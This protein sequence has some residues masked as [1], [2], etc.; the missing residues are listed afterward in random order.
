MA[1]RNLFIDYRLRVI[2]LGLVM[3]WLATGAFAVAGARDPGIT[4]PLVIYPLGAM[5]AGLALLTITPW[6][7]VLNRPYG[8]AVIAIWCAM[9]VGGVLV[10]DGLGDGAGD[11]VIA[12]FIA[13][14]VFAAAALVAP[15][16]L[17]VVSFLALGGYVVTLVGGDANFSDL[18]VRFAAFGLTAVLLLVAAGGI[19]NQVQTAAKRLDELGERDAE[20]TKRESELEKLYDISRTIGAGVNLAEVLPELVG[21]LAHAVEARTGLVLLYRPESE[22]LEV[23]SPIWVAGHTVRVDGYTLPLQDAGIAQRVFTSGSAMVNNELETPHHDPFL[24]DLD[25]G[26]IALVP[27]QI[28]ARV[29]GVLAVADRLEGEFTSDEVATLESLAGPSAL[30][31]N[32]MARYEEARE[33]GEK[34]AELA[35]LKTEF[36]SIVSHEL[37]TPLTSIIGSLK[38]LSRPELAPADPNA[39]ELLSTAERQAQRLRT[40]IEDLLVVSRLD[41]QALPVRPVNIDLTDFLVEVVGDVPG[42]PEAVTVA[43]ELPSEKI[44]VD[45]DHLGRVLRNLLENALRYAPGSEIE[46][47]AVQRGEEVWIS[48]IDHGPGIPYDLHDHIFDRFTQIGH[49]ATRAQ[50]GTGLGLSIVR[51]LTEAMGGRVWFEPTPGGGATFSVALPVRSAVRGVRQD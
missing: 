27:L 1:E 24:A 38:T 49:S 33:T 4:H 14:V 21:R 23:M 28:E 20:L 7:R 10:V 37:R 41:N 50:G 40:L 8:D 51:G 43:P 35:E 9:A 13:A 39:Q 45:A 48:I 26:Q 6:R 17:G 36:V 12:G 22:A 42:A 3:S 5:V 31:L 16:F 2:A 18:A 46:L 30:V 34:M 32:Q 47:G 15:L 25:A 44:Y 19:R 11:A 29:I